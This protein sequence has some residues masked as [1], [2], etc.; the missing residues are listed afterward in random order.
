MNTQSTEPTEPSASAPLQT[1]DPAP[2]PA[3]QQP[4]RRWRRARE[5]AWRGQRLQELKAQ[6]L[7]AA[8]QL[9]V[10]EAR[11]CE[12]LARRTLAGIEPIPARARDA[13]ARPLI[14]AGIGKCLPLLRPPPSALD[15]IFHDDTW[16]ERLIAGGVPAAEQA[17]VR[18]WLAGAASEQRSA[19][20]LALITLTTLLESIDHNALAIRSVYWRRLRVVMATFAVLGG[21]VALLAFALMP[22]EGPDLAA[23]K[24]W[25]A[26]SAY[27]GYAVSGIKPARATE[28]ALFCT[29][30]DDQPWWSL[31]MGAASSI[32]SVT[33]VNRAD[34][35]IE[36]APPLVVE[37][38]VDGKKWREV[39]R[40]TEAFRTWRPKFRATTAR[41]V[42][43]RSLRRTY[44]HMKDVRV[45]PA[46]KR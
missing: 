12:T 21:L 11:S 20:E 3:K 37:V 33:I 35:C 31:D 23:G 24:R 17:S 46:I 1:A 19:G 25:E 44:L 16:R 10:E 32:G 9:A 28:P 39:A 8:Q 14:E 29:N 45:H 15:D 40:T 4:P 26:S 18:A 6:R 27:V 13:V 7:S 30:E 2:A 36:R 5:W 22:P 41:F 38:S 43:L 42:R 34:C